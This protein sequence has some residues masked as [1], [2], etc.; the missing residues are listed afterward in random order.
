MP[1]T[2]SRQLYNPQIEAL[3]GKY[4]TAVGDRAAKPFTGAELQGIAPAVA[5]QTALQN[6]QNVFSLNMAQ[7]NADQQTELANSKFL[8]T[9]SLTEAN[10]DQQAAV[11]NAVLLSQANLAEADFYQKS[12]IQNAQ[13]FLGM[14]MATLNNEQE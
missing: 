8:Q 12:Q 7:F 6:A 14:D 5:Q 1:V 13:A 4:A 11:Q 9:V 2:E 10:F 3:M